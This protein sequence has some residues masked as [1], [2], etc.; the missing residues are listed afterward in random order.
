MLTRLADTTDQTT[1]QE[2]K[3]SPH[4][5]GVSDKIRLNI[6]EKLNLQI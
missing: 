6:G 1:Y 2:L 3:L 5:S 4:N